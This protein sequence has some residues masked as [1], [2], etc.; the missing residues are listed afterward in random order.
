MQHRHGLGV[1]ELAVLQLHV[2]RIG[3]LQLKGRE[4]IGIG[5]P[6]G[7]LAQVLGH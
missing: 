6:H 5:V 2:A 1:K 3:I 7:L 4:H